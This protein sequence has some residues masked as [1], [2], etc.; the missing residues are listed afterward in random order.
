MMGM[1]IPLV[2][3]DTIITAPQRSMQQYR[4]ILLRLIEA[5][6]C[7]PEEYDNL[8]FSKLDIKDGFWRMVVETGKQLNFAM[9]YIAFKC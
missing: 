2:N 1:E 9:C 7:A 5:V 4:K 6:V 8:V 3:K